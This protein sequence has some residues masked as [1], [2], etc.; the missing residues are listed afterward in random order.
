ML[1]GQDLFDRSEEYEDMLQ[2]GLRLSGER[3]DYF[4]EGRVRD[5]VARLGPAYRPRRILDF[6]CGT[7]ETSAHLARVFPGA[8][9]TGVDTAENAV[10]HARQRSRSARLRFERLRDF[11]AVEAFD[12]CYTNGVFHHIRP[13]E[14]IAAARTIH[15]AL[16]SGGRFALME[17]NPWN[18]GTRLVMRR[19]A[20]D[21]DAIPLSPPEARNL[22]RDSG[23][24]RC[25]PA[26]FLFYF[27][28]A[29]A[30]LRFLEP[31]LVRLPLG[32]QYYFL[33][34]KA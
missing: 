24:P 7:G 2:R 22:L 19:I 33:A 11:D 23:F 30:A 31:W 10:A 3:R 12:L 17:N 13:S 16:V 18:P 15:R 8:E 20:F 14:R 32:A 25:E 6:G 4:M 1:A 34:T 26:R 27:P 9:V 28:R 29:L 5:L 21:R